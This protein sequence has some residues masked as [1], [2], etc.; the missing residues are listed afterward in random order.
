M[1]TLRGRRD[2]AALTSRP[3]QG[4]SARPSTALT[5]WRQPRAQLSV[6]RTE[7][8]DRGGSERPVGSP[9]V[10]TEAMVHPQLRLAVCGLLA[11]PSI[12]CF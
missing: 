10:P 4:E 2:R 11:F 8:L 1:V 5:V 12:A 6:G 7:R 3:G 9:A